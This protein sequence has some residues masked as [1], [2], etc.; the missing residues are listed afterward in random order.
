MVYMLQFLS[1]IALGEL[2]A[3]SDCKIFSNYFLSL[4]SKFGSLYQQM[5]AE[6]SQH[7]KMLRSTIKKLL[8]IP[9]EL[10][11][12]FRGELLYNKSSI[13]EK[14]ILMHASFEPA[15]FSY[16]TVLHKFNF[17]EFEEFLAIKDI[18][19]NILLDEG[20]HMSIG[21]EAIEY[22]KRGAEFTANKSH[23]AESLARHNNL[24]SKIPSLTLGYENELTSKIE[25]AFKRNTHSAFRKVFNESTSL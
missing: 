25:D 6:E 2:V 18:S 9:K 23:L 14:L 13:L 16:M 10:K 11:S 4:N 24:L 19:K 22:V 17:Q 20:N 5:E 15:A 8:P 7:Y 12:M 1:C 3:A 21:F